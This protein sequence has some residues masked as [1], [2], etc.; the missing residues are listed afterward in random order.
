ML[1]LTDISVARGG[2]TILAG[3]TL[4]LGAGEMLALR[5]PNGSGKTTLLRAVAGLQPVL[6]GTLVTAPEGV[7]YIA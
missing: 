6:S 5:G 2:V 7:A 3:V 1:E 4:R